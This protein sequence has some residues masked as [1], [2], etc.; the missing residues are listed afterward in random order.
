MPYSDH[1]LINLLPWRESVVNKR[2]KRVS[3][4]VSVSLILLMLLSGA[5][6]LFGLK[7]IEQQILRNQ[8]IRAANQQIGIRIQAGLTRLRPRQDDLELLNYLQVQSNLLPHTAQR[9][10][11]LASARPDGLSYQLLLQ[12]RGVLRLQGIV[13]DQKDLD[14]L[15]GGLSDKGM[16]KMRIIHLQKY[17]QATEFVVEIPTEGTG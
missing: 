4:Y 7:Y 12:T 17:D 8:E 5:W 10:S 1:S 16:D 14:Y 9:L 6:S 3:F 13:R 15:I 2:Y 11:W